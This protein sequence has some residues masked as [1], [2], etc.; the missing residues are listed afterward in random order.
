MHI[1][2]FSQ[3]SKYS[4]TYNFNFHPYIM[5][6]SEARNWVLS[7]LICLYCLVVFIYKKGRYNITNI[8]IKAGLI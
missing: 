5:N 1:I 4:I 8:G 7:I 2:A 6:L 3:Y